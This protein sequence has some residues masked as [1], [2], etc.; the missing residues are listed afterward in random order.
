VASDSQDRT[1]F[2]LRA[3]YIPRNISR[4]RI[5]FASAVPFDASIIGAADDGL[6]GDWTLNVQE[7]TGGRWLDFSSP[8][9]TP[10]PFAS[11]GPLIRLDF[12][13]IYS[14]PIT[15]IY[16]DDSVNANGQS[17]E[18]KDVPVVAPPAV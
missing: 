9:G 7:T 4:F 14:M 18:V 13:G 16:L 3:D 8:S 15:G 11:F 6:A 12:N 10:I 1:T 2:F 5:W 17:F